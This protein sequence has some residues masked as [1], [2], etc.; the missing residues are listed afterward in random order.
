MV[1]YKT[2]SAILIAAAASVQ[3][4]LALDITRLKARQDSE[5]VDP[6]NNQGPNDNQ[7]PG[8]AVNDRTSGPHQVYLFY[9]QTALVGFTP[10]RLGNG[11][12]ESLENLGAYKP[13]KFQEVLGKCLQQHVDQSQFC[14]TKYAHS[15]EYDIAADPDGKNDPGNKSSAVLCCEDGYAL[16]L[17]NRRP[18]DDPNPDVRINCYNS[19]LIANESLSALLDIYKWKPV[20]NPS[21]GPLKE[22]NST[23][24][25]TLLTYSYWSEDR[26]W[27][28]ST[29]YRSDNTCPIE[30]RY[31]WVIKGNWTDVDPNYAPPTL[32]DSSS[33][34]EPTD[35]PTP[36]STQSD[37]MEPTPTDD[38]PSI[39]TDA[40]PA[41]TIAP[42]ETDVVT[43]QTR[44]PKSVVNTEGASAIRTSDAMPTPTPTSGPDDGLG[45]GDF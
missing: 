29:Y 4:T 21:E 1:K 26:T 41:P 35:D 17:L 32:D 9:N 6:N 7:S 8:P 12:G 31:T 38:M 34:D 33:D 2:L 44:P 28:I 36:S 42:P 3:V 25:T 22:P 40:I 27:G 37:M 13:G 16:Y 15:V 11:T 30:D 24:T 5:T 20:L 23:V 14:I 10:E 45:D 43:I 18:R 39:P 19:M